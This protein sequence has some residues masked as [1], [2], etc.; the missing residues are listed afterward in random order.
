[1]KRLVVLTGMSGATG[2]DP[3]DCAGCKVFR[4]IELHFGFGGW[5]RGLRFQGVRHFRKS[6]RLGKFSGPWTALNQKFGRSEALS[7]N[8]WLEFASS[9]N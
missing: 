5:A 4:R 8:C 6:G 9:G 2:Q 1:M 3:A 7:Y